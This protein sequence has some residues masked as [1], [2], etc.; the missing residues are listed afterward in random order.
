MGY[1]IKDVIMCKETEKLVKILQGSQNP[2]DMALIILANKMDS[3]NE[4][5]DTNIRELDVKFEKRFDELTTKTDK[6]IEELRKATRFARWMDSHKKPLM[7]IST[8]LIVLATCG[9]SGVVAWIK[10][11]L[12]I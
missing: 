10:T 9:I 5:I 6:Q 11:K 4:K 2:T 8:L 3:I 12:G 1:N 7:A